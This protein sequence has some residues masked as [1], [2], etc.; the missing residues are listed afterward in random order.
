MVSNR[1][2]MSKVEP[3]QLY[4]QLKQPCFM[5]KIND[6]PEVLVIL[7]IQYNNCG[8]VLLMMELVTI[9]LQIRSWVVHRE[10]L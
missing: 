7:S 9:K 6:P 3:T 1:F 2:R 8:G 10:V 5:I 4:G